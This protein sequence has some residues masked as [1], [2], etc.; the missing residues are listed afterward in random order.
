M[1]EPVEIYVE[2]KT[3]FGSLHLTEIVGQSA[4]LV[5]KRAPFRS[6]REYL[7]GGL[8]VVDVKA[9]GDESGYVGRANWTTPITINL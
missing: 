9:S 1:G 6:A 5:K 8:E 2:V 7:V 4:T 3:E